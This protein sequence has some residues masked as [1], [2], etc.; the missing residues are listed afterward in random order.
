MRRPGQRST[1][2]V[3]GYRLLGFLLV[4]AAVALAACG[5]ASSASSPPPS[6]AVL[7]SGTSQGWVFHDGQTVNVSMGPNRLFKP[8]SHVNIVECSDPGGKAA[9]QPTKFLDCDENTIQ[10][11][12]ILVHAGGAFSEPGYAVFKLPNTTIGD[13]RDGV[14]V[15]NST[16]PCVLLVSEYQTDLSKPKAFS[17]P[18]IV[19]PADGSQSGS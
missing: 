16:N 11:N 7:V 18:F 12:T 6:S 8:L 13:T 5:G 4:G 1:P 17:R 14:P 3:E 10:G 2:T 15:C 9:N 19:L